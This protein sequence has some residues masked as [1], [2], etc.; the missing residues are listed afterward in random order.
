MERPTQ[1]PPTE[2][3][4]ERDADAD[5]DAYAV[6][7]DRQFVTALARGLEVLRCFRQTDVALGNQEI[8]ERTGLPKPTVS[9]LTHTLCRLGYLAYSPR[10]NKYQLG[11]GV[12][13]LGYAYLAGLDLRD[14]ARPMMQELATQTNASV[15]LGSRDRLEMVYVECCRGSGVVTLSLDV[16]SRIPIATTAMGR[17][18]LTA[19]PVEER[20][21]LVEHVQRKQPDQ[22]DR[23][24]AGVE[25]AVADVA[26]RGFCVSIGDWHR[27]LHAA[28]VPVVLPQRE[29]VFA[30]NCGGP[31]FMLS[32]AQLTEQIGPRLVEIARSL[33]MPE[34]RSADAPGAQRD[35]RPD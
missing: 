21:Y 6:G 23:I 20:Q 10:L 3:T 31:S 4:A 18:L 8:T 28:G 25:Q 35:M 17:A 16:G 11:S 7:R 15:G 1:P 12:L 33:S 2:P 27:D 24:K 9:R 26:E 32:P 29:G 19:L 14:R 13:A 34:A 5:A 22:A 30:I